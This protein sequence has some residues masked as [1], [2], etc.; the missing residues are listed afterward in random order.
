VARLLENADPHTLPYWVIGVFCGL[1]SAELRRLD[2]EDI[3]WDEKLLEVPTIKSKTASRRFVQLH[4]NALAWLLPYRDRRGLVCPPNLNGRLV[5]DRHTAGIRQWPPN[6]CRHSF[7]SYHLSHF[8]DP[9]ELA[10]EMG[11]SR[12]EVTFRHYRELVRPVEAERFWKIAPA[13]CG[14]S[15]VAVA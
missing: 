4:E 13:V 7:A 5:A 1:R 2:W 8:R 11:H 14:T 12:S 6:A 15:I 9:R 10:L 3:H